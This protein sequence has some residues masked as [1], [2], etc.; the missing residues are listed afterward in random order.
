MVAPEQFDGR[1]S[2]GVRGLT[3]LEQ[4]FLGDNNL[5]GPIPEELANLLQL[6]ELSLIRNGFTGGIPPE[7]GALTSLT[8]LLLS[9]NK[10]TGEIPPELGEMPKLTILLLAQNRLS[11]EIPA[12]FGTSELRHLRLAGNR[13]T[14]CVPSALHLIEHNDTDQ[15]DLPDCSEPPP[16]PPDTGTGLA[17]TPHSALPAAV[18]VFATIATVVAILGIVAGLRT[19][20]CPLTPPRPC[21]PRPPAVSCRLPSHHPEERPMATV[22]ITLKVKEGMEARYEEIQKDLYEKTH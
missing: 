8:V 2:S 17:P 13:L 10:L 3:S 20:R 15:L 7:L 11:G 16:E 19:R 6:R 5:T 4:L 1:D 12:G 9:D 18:N 21:R 22:L 14:G